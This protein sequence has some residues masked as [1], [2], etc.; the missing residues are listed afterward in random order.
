MNRN[1]GSPTKPQP[2]EVARELFVKGMSWWNRKKVEKALRCFQRAHELN[3]EDPHITS[4]LGLVLV[5]S[6]IYDKGLELCRGAL[7]KSPSNADLLFNLGQAYLLSSRRNEARLT[8]LRGARVCEDKHRFMDA[9]TKMGIRRK[10]I[11]RFLSRE[12]FLNRWLG[13]VTYRPGMI[14]SIQD[15]AS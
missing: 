4:Y 7:R 13:K 12:N 11:I 10:P 3:S 14:Y 9:L 5:D 2:S 15:I 8:L 1:E 6:G